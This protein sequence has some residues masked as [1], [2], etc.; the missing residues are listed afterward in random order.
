MFLIQVQCRT[1]KHDLYDLSRPVLFLENDS[2]V[3]LNPVQPKGKNKRFCYLSS[4][5]IGLAL[6]KS[7]LCQKNPK[8]PQRIKARILWLLLLHTGKDITPGHGAATLKLRCWKKSI[9]HGLWFRNKTNTGASHNDWRIVI[10]T[11]N[12][13]NSPTK[14]PSEISGAGQIWTTLPT[15]TAILL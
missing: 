5:K 6:A 11:P 9:S 8:D 3:R 1:R 2:I 4:H 12:P 15:D 13:E 10:L 14:G 7:V